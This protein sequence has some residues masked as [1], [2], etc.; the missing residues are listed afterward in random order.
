M[1]PGGTTAPGWAVAP[2]STW[3]P[4]GATAWHKRFYRLAH[5]ALLNGPYSRPKKPSKCPVG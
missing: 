3:L 2:P 1:Q 4:G 5:S